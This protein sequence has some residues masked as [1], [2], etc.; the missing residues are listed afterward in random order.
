M[1]SD[2]K[3]ARARKLA[4]GWRDM[5][6]WLPPD[7]VIALEDLKER[8]PES[9]KNDLIVRAIIHL[10]DNP[11]AVILAESENNGTFTTLDNMNVDIMHLRSLVGDL[12]Q[13][14]EALESVVNSVR[15]SLD[16]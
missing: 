12:L 4:D 5:S 2:R 6:V 8:M 15:P 9:S 3:T 10:A 14:V 7:A 13:R 11:D 1:S 16:E